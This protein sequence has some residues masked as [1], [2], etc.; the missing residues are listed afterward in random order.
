M[1]DE[2]QAKFI[3]GDKTFL[4]DRALIG[5]PDGTTMPLPLPQTHIAAFTPSVPHP[6]KIRVRG[7]RMVGFM[8]PLRFGVMFKL[9]WTDG[10]ILE[11]IFTDVQGAFDGGGIFYLNEAD[12][13]VFSYI[14]I[15]PN[16]PGHGKVNGWYFFSMLDRWVW[17]FA[18]RF[19][20]QLED[21]VRELNRLYSPEQFGKQK[22]KTPTADVFSQS[23]E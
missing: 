21:A 11:K 19:G 9:E 14:E 20:L 13:R 2:E 16:M 17:K 22:E 8:L 5:L 23:A 1:N 18:L 12:G 15:D 7:H 6:E 4:V 3:W 10:M